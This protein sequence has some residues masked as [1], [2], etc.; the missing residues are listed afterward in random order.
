MGDAVYLP[1]EFDWSQWVER[2]DLM[3]ERYLVNRGGRFAEIFRL[4]RSTQ[5]ATARILDLGC[6]PGSLGYYLL[7]NLPQ[8]QI[9]GVDLDPTLLVL[10]E[11]RMTRF[12]SRAKFIRADME[13]AS[14]TDVLPAPFDAVVSATALHWLPPDHLVILYGQIAQLLRA[15]GIFLNADH[16]GS[17]FPPIQNAWEKDRDAALPKENNH[18][19]DDWGSFWKEYGRALKIDVD[20]IHQQIAGGRQH[21]PENGMPLA[22]QV[23]TLRAKGF[24]SVECF[25]RSYCDAIYGGIK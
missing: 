14:W 18:T 13:T 25:W 19:A 10:A 24:H 16:A 8:A 9:I 1:P 4:I 12:G 17:D 21:G 11:V 5:P 3:Q 23:D 22:W 15:G 2:W 7:D 20:K 6:G